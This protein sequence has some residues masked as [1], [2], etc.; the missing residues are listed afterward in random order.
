MSLSEQFVWRR[1]NPVDLSFRDKTFPATVGFD[2]LKVDSRCSV[3]GQNYDEDGDNRKKVNRSFVCLCSSGCFLTAMADASYLLARNVSNQGE[4]EEAEMIIVVT[5]GRVYQLELLAVHPTALTC[6]RRRPL[7]I[8]S[9][10]GPT[11]GLALRNFGE[12]SRVARA[13]ASQAT[14]ATAR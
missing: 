6:A 5:V 3:S 10:P 2:W 13:P 4:R 7:F 8:V 12:G 1:F 11:F 14:P 9:L